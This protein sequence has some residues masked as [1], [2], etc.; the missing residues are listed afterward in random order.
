MAVLKQSCVVFLLWV[1]WVDLI[2]G[3]TPSY[4][5]PYCSHDSINPNARAIPPLTGIQRKRVQSLEQVQVIAR[6]G[7]RSPALR[8]C[9]CW[10]NYQPWNNCNVSELMI[11]TI[12]KTVTVPW[13][14]R[15]VYDGSPNY[16]HGD[17]MSGQLLVEGYQQ[18]LRNGQLLRE[19]YLERTS[20]SDLLLFQSR[21]WSEVE[22]EV[23][24]RSDDEQRTLMSGQLI[25]N[26]MFQV[27]P[28]YA[29]LPPSSLLVAYLNLST[30]YFK[31]SFHQV[32]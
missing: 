12:S 24:I 18:E 22:S 14:Y 28:S 13:Y 8:E 11:E 19:A 7:A 3:Y 5:I 26:E 10:R 30:V 2:T 15:K 9:K 16:L 31:H 20:D 32:Q 25:V 23:Y 4:N 29:I 21:N 6:H 17:C 1:L 27:S